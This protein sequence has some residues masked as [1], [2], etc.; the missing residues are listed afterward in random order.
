[1]TST[2]RTFT[3]SASLACLGALAGAGTARSQSRGPAK[4]KR[5]LVMQV[6]ENPSKPGY[7]PAG[8]FMHFGVRG[9]PLNF[10]QSR[11]E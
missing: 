8:L 1:M 11:R 6:M 4:S 9:D 3:K 2:R 7:I 5:D 10:W